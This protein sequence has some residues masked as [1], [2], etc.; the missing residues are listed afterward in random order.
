ML[1]FTMK[2]QKIYI[3]TLALTLNMEPGKTDARR[4]E[5]RRREVRKDE[6]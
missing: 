4:R 2:L 6:E 5:I 3:S 1:K